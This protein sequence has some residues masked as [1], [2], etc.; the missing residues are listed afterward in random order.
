[1]DCMGNQKSRRSTDQPTSPFPPCSPRLRQHWHAPNQ[2]PLTP[3]HQSPSSHCPIPPAILPARKHVSCGGPALAVPSDSPSIH[4]LAGYLV[5]TSSQCSPSHRSCLP[6]WT[7]DRFNTKASERDFTISAMFPL[8][9]PAPTHSQPTFSPFL[10]PQPKAV[11]ASEV[12]VGFTIPQPNHVCRRGWE[13]LVE[14]LVSSLGFQPIPDTHLTPVIH[15]PCH[16]QCLLTSARHQQNRSHLR[17]SYNKMRRLHSRCG[18]ITL[19]PPP[20]PHLHPPPN[21]QVDMACTRSGFKKSATRV[22]QWPG[23]SPTSTSPPPL[24]LLN[25]DR[26]PSSEPRSLS[27]QSPVQTCFIQDPRPNAPQG[28]KSLFDLTTNG[29]ACTD[30]MTDGSSQSQ[31][32]CPTP[33]DPNPW[34]RTKPG[35]PMSSQVSNSILDS[36]N[37]GSFSGHHNMGAPPH[38]NSGTGPSTCRYTMERQ[39]QAQALDLATDFPTD[40]YSSP[41][42]ST[43]SQARAGRSAQG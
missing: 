16:L 9:T 2:H 41:T 15:F 23:H 8:A 37:Y 38:G 28:E 27:K 14:E 40:W 3:S 12:G 36:H 11:F 35:S 5:R 7:A 17:I 18:Q 39:G 6:N 30:T 21:L 4:L 32:W 26:K 34:S 42:N 22:G 29:R 43:I 33:A 10:P 13:R 20:R 1:M 24:S 25:Q 19:Q 31:T